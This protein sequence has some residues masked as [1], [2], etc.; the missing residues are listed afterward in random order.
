M[1]ERFQAERPSLDDL[2]A[3][4]D[5]DGTVRLG[6]YLA[7]VEALTA[8]KR[9]REEQGLSLADVAEASGIDRAAISRLENG[10]NA[11]PTVE[12]LDRYAAAVGKRLA[13]V[14]EDGDGPAG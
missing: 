6:T 1:R 10:R 13:W 9:A 5:C 7:L 3:T 14:V 12:T 8:L 11:N 2:L 4:G